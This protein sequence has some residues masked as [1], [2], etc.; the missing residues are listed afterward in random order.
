MFRTP[1]VRVINLIDI[2]FFGVT[3]LRISHSSSAGGKNWVEVLRVVVRMIT[4][5]GGFRMDSFGH[6]AV[7]DVRKEFYSYSL[8]LITGLISGGQVSRL[9]QISS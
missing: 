1:P 7:A 5:L 8:S 4:P 3:R 9:K 6:A 2:K